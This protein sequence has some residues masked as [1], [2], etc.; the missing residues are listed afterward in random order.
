MVK[1]FS[2]S[3]DY[4]RFIIKIVTHHILWTFPFTLLPLGDQR[5]DNPEGKRYSRI[6]VGK[7]IDALYGPCRV[8]CTRTTC[9]FDH[10]RHP[11]PRG[12]SVYEGLGASRL[13]SRLLWHILLRLCH[14]F[15]YR[16]IPCNCFLTSGL[17]CPCRESI[18][19]SL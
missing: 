13:S 7:L 2:R 5:H 4:P 8:S 11:S 10:G 3:S 6:S 17:L 14:C 9:R 15:P 16:P 1:V 19:S 18:Q 12:S